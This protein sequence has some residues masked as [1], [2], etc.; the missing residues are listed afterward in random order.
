MHGV[1]PMVHPD[2]QRWERMCA[3]SAHEAAERRRREEQM[4][5]WGFQQARSREVAAERAPEGR[6]PMLRPR[7]AMP[8]HRVAYHPAPRRPGYRKPKTR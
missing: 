5:Q 3:R 4:C 8:H 7:E 2:W 1:Q 6:A